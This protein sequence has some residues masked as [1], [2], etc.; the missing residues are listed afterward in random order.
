MNPLVEALMQVQGTRNEVSEIPPITMKGLHDALTGVVAGVG[1]LPVDLATMAMRPF[2]YD[3]QNPVMSTEWIGEQLGADVE[4]GPFMLGMFGAPDPM[5]MLKVATLAPA[6][7]KAV[8][9]NKRV[10]NKVLHESTRGPPRDE[11]RAYKAGQ[12]LKE[13]G[14]SMED[15]I[16]RG[17]E[18]IP[19]YD[20]F[21]ETAATAVFL[22]AGIKGKGLPRYVTGWR[23]GGIPKGDRS[24]NFM[25]NTY[26]NG[27]SLMRADGI[28]FKGSTTFELFNSAGARKVKVGGFYAGRGSDGE[29]LVVLAK[30]IGK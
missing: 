7:A 16:Y 20:S 3:E 12:L 23:Y 21:P 28:D 27:V 18:G 11:K 1:G 4:S 8:K 10:I 15:W 30:E 2:G 26:E 13:S 5:D 19:N 22:E 25:D 9:K 14:K 24:I 29:P 6:V 17:I